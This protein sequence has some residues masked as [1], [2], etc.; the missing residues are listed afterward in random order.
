[1]CVYV[2]VNVY[3]HVCVW[4]RSSKLF[5]CICENVKKEN[6]VEILAL[7]DSNWGK[8]TNETE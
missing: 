3:V 2:R 5:P 1:M 8:L 6:E 7:S 4:E